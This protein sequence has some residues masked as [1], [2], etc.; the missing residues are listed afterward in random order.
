MLWYTEG[1][2]FLSQRSKTSDISKSSTSPSNY[3]FHDR[4]ELLNWSQKIHV[5]DF[6]WWTVPD[7]CPLICEWKFLNRYLLCRSCILWM[8]IFIYTFGYDIAFLVIVATK[9]SPPHK[10][11][12]QTFRYFI[13][14]YSVCFF[15]KKNSN[16]SSEFPIYKFKKNKFRVL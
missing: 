7:N 3:I 10:W 6:H 15:L 16:L 5:S 8:Y 13:V 4:V 1:R 14:T 11:D 2:L 12:Y 9:S